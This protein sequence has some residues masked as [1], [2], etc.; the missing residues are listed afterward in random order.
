ML[1]LAVMF[2]AVLLVNETVGRR[3]V[4]PEFLAF[5]RNEAAREA[6]RVIEAIDTE[7]N[8]L[9]E[10]T[11]HWITDGDQPI[12]SVSP[13][14]D[15][16]WAFIVDASMQTQWLLGADFQ[17]D[18][19]FAPL[20]A[21]LPITNDG[22]TTDPQHSVDLPRGIVRLADESVCI[23]AASAIPN[24]GVDSDPPQ[25]YLV[26]GR[27]VNESVIQR[28]RVQTLVDFEILP[29]RTA[30]VD[31]EI[32]YREQGDQLLAELTIY[33]PIQSN[34]GT[35]L[36]RTPRNII[37][38]A[39]RTFGTA[40]NVFILGIIAALLLLLLL[41]QRIVIGPLDSV[42]EHLD[43]I[44]VNGSPSAPLRLETGDEIGDLALAFDAMVK[45]LG[46]TQRE[47]ASASQAAGRCEV[48]ASVI[49]NVGNVLTNVNSL[50][51]AAGDRVEQLHVD[52]LHRLAIRLQETEDSDELFSETPGYLSSLANQW[53]SD[54]HAI[55]RMLH[56]LDDNVRHIHD[57]IRDQQR[58][59]DHAIE[60][61]PTNVWKVLVDAISCCQATFHEESIQVHI[62]ADSELSV[63]ADHSLLLQTI[64]N[65]IGNCVPAMKR[66]N[67]ADRTITL[68]AT[69][70]RANDKIRI[71]VRD[72]GCG[73]T[74]ETMDRAFEPYFTRREGGTG[75]G[76]HFCAN[77]IKQFGGTITA[78]SDGIGSGTTLTIE[79]HS[80]D[81]IDA[82]PDPSIAFE[83]HQEAI[84]R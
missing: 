39:D 47:L 58:F 2:M 78:H 42:R 7:I 8:H 13:N 38:R 60:H 5:E 18:A 20:V 71:S 27:E 31:G 16:R 12:E 45:R 44:G 75:L 59:A 35:L 51:D 41:L 81:S 9:R 1:S 55:S 43:T 54:Q 29:A 25:Q 82:A 80:V 50:L 23:Y 28:L 64:I 15:I 49:H 21:T 33:G 22:T 24:N 26:L 40:R 3:V 74:A 36:I 56:T 83:S 70:I 76:L 69:E 10:L 73:M 67:Q 72:N 65:L 11:Q 52:P 68:T 32:L 62:D 77:T 17:K 57:I 30:T 48:A 6:V 66:S 37:H 19:A 14:D 4:G 53:K 79:L 84:A 46:E 63:I 61:T 34:L